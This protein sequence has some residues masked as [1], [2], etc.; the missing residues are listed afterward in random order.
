MQSN[1]PDQANMEQ[2]QAKSCW[3]AVVGTVDRSFL[4][5]K[6]EFWD[7]VHSSHGPQDQWFWS[8]N[9]E[10]YMFKLITVFDHDLLNFYVKEYTIHLKNVEF[11]FV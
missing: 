1:G 5:L 6:C 3:M 8:A 2:T 10:A 7:M 9:E 4:Y 11:T